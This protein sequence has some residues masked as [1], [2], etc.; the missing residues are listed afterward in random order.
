M[1][2]L[3]LTA[4][5][6]AALVAVAAARMSAGV[7]HTAPI[8]YVAGSIPAAATVTALVCGTLGETAAIGCVA[9]CICAVTDLATGLIFDE[10]VALGLIACLYASAGSGTQALGGCVAGA[11]C[12][13]ALLAL[14]RVATRRGLGWG[15]V[16]LGA[17]V[18]AALGVRLVAHAIGLAFVIGALSVL[19]GLL[20]GRRH[21]GDRIAFAPYLA[22]ATAFAAVVLSR[23][24]WRATA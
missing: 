3:A 13:F 6:T 23:V 5:V 19:P 8:A 17:V 20:R 7:R 12:G 14:V 15:D 24:D 2:T 16:K 21:F 4:A 10:V 1:T 18:G 22:I 9:A 11:T